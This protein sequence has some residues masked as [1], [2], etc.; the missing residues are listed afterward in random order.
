MGDHRSRRNVLALGSAALLASNLP[1]LARSAGWQTMLPADAG[2]AA[3]LDKRFDA[4]RAAGKL[5]NLHGVVAL[6]GGRIFFERY[7]TGIDHRGGESLGEVSFGPDTLHDMRSVTKSIVGLLYGIALADRRV[8]SP[9]Q[10]LLAQFAEYPDLAKDPARARLTVANALTMTLGTEWNESVP[11]TDPANGEIA[12]NNAPDRYR[13]ILDRPIIAPP[14]QVWT[15]NG[16]A[17]A[18][19]GRLI[20][21]GTGQALPDFAQTSLFEPLGI[22]SS[23]WHKGEDGEANAASG[24][25]LT[26]RD[27]ARIG[28]M[29]RSDGK[30]NDR[31][32]VPLQWLQ[33]SF[34]PAAMVHPGQDYGYLW[35]VGEIGMRFH[36]GTR[37]HPYVLAWGNG[38]QCLAI[39]PGIDLVVAITV[40]NYNSPNDAQTP[41][42]LLTEVLLSGLSA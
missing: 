21:K 18:L 36:S 16:G 4:L 27:L 38:G 35:R 25:R 23:E 41:F 6:H 28:Q 3:D 34:K 2:F 37:G 31:P 24:L 11:Y 13:F 7:L 1:L 39:F 42:T 29:V 17:A 30:W 32:V 20:E 9:D 15:Y 14:G 10:S 12:M 5:A 33:A 26:P 19:V 22:A 40:G 8:P